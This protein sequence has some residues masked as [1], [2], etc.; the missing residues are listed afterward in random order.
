MTIRTMQRA[1]AAGRLTEAQC[2]EL[3]AVIEEAE[4]NEDGDSGG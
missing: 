2:A 1:F 4:Q 3:V